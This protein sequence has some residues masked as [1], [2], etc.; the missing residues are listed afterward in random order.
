MQMAE[1]DTGVLIDGRYRV[2]RQLGV[3]GMARVLLARDEQLGREVAVK[4]FRPLSRTIRRTHIAA[5]TRS[6]CSPA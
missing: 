2:I 1:I 6:R 5:A 4:V 3:G